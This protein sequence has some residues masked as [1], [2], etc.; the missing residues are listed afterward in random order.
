M[1]IS[2]SRINSHNYHRIKIPSRNKSILRSLAE[3]DTRIRTRTR[4]RSQDRCPKE[5]AR[6]TSFRETAKNFYRRR[7]RLRRTRRWNFA[8][9][10]PPAYIRAGCRT[11]PDCSVQFSRHPIRRRRK[12]ESPVCAIPPRFYH[13][14]YHTPRPC[15]QQQV[16][17]CEKRPHRG[18]PR[19][20]RNP[21]D[22]ECAKVTIAKNRFRPIPVA[23]RPKYRRARINR[24]SSPDLEFFN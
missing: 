5:P 11:A 18:R 13:T 4:D 14:T 16:G 10:K 23:A 20:L 2:D 6:R 9:W 24:V 21:R 15:Y 3:V 19:I 8:P 12:L 1:L 7:M 17:E 22:C